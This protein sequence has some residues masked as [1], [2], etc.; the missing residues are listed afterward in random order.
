MKNCMEKKE[1]KHLNSNMT[2]KSHH[3]AFTVNNLEESISWYQDKLGFKIIYEYKKGNMEFALL[4]LDSV[5]IE[6][7]SFVDGTKPI[8]NYRKKLM[9]DLHV[10]GT[11]HLCIEVEKLDEAVEKLK[12]KKVEFVTEVDS[13]A[14][15]GHY[16]FFKDINGILIELYSP[17]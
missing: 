15:G 16:I 4:K 6:L 12:E 7:F 14:F 9:D 2:F 11:K 1:Q 3:T 10:A 17:R 8:P 13:A 5:K